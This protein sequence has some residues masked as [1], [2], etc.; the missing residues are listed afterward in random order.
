MGARRYS[1]EQIIVKLRE[2]EIEMGRGVKV[3]EVCRKPGISEQTFY[4]WRK[5]YGEPAQAGWL[6]R[7]RLGDFRRLGRL[8]QR[9]AG[10]RRDRYLGPERA[11][12]HHPLCAHRLGDPGAKPLRT[13]F[14]RLPHT[15]PAHHPGGDRTHA[16]LTTTSPCRSR[17]GRLPSLARCCPDQRPSDVCSGMVG[18]GLF[19]RPT[20]DPRVRLSPHAASAVM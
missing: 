5:R 11:P 1:T 4:R 18:A 20:G 15:D 12:P 3:P 19:G 17:S 8:A 16:G 14:L 2:A 7:S 13:H 6:R 9:Q 10:R